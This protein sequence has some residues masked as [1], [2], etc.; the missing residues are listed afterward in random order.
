[1]LDAGYR[2]LGLLGKALGEFRLEVGEHAE[3]VVAEQHLP[4]RAD[5]GA[6]A[7]GRDGELL[8]I[9][10]RTVDGVVAL[11]CALPPRR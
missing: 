9:G 1:L 10:E 4:I 2:N 3:Q 11:S 8:R 6:N 5:A 7:D